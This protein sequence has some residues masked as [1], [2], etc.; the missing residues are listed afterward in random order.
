MNPGRAYVSNTVNSA[1]PGQLIVMLY[2]GLM[3]FAGDARDELVAGRTG[4]EPISRAIRILTELSRCLRPDASP[5]LCRNL[6]NLYQFYTVELSK[7]MHEQK[8][9]R[10]DKIIPLIQELRDAWQVAE[11]K[12]SGNETGDAPPPSAPPAA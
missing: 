12:N 5:E 1:T 11:D 2:D 4:A 3:R 8:P 9:E 10:I 6:A 7:A